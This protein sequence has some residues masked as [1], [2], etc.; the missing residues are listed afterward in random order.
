[1]NKHGRAAQHHSGKAQQQQQQAQERAAG[2]RQQQA[3]APHR[4]LIKVSASPC[5]PSPT[6]LW[7][8]FELRASGTG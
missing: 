1:M 8:M 3:M 4:I 2:S 6:G 7:R 5:T